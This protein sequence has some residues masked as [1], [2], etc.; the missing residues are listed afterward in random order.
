[1]AIKEV[2]AELLAEV[3]SEVR[4]DLS[5]YDITLES[6]QA[7]ENVYIAQISAPNMSSWNLDE[8]VFNLKVTASTFGDSENSSSSVDKRTQDIIDTNTGTPI[9]DNC[10]LRIIENIKPTVHIVSPNAND[11]PTN[12]PQ[13][14]FK[15]YDCK[16]DETSTIKDSGI[17]DGTVKIILTKPDGTSTTIQE[18][19]SGNGIT[20]GSI[21]GNRYSEIYNF[22]YSPTTADLVQGEGTYTVSITVSDNDGNES[23][24][25]VV[26]FIYNA[27]APQITITKE[28]PAYV[29]TPAVTIEGFIT[30][31]ESLE[32]SKVYFDVY[33][34]DNNNNVIDNKE[35]ITVVPDSANG[36]FKT[37]LELFD[38]CKNKIEI[39]A[40]DA[41]HNISDQPQVVYVIV[42]STIPNFKYVEVTP[43]ENG[44]LK[45]T[46][47]IEAV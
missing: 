22:T 44:L 8:N 46:V 18:G 26:S 23:E 31:T 34:L 10:K 24:P 21:E 19:V 9:G 43:L 35:R 27:N 11:A 37:T 1:M 12:S 29:A 42:D 45:I 13:I 33:S 16:K 47:K 20:E 3:G 40:E 39:R 36:V 30:D 25:A 6:D 14:I 17:K 28:V 5:V 41:N 38:N 2:K 32:G 7:N 4:T 15:A